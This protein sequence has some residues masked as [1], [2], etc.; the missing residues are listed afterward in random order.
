MREATE[1]L[2]Y[3][4]RGGPVHPLNL[5]A[6]LSVARRPPLRV[7][8]KRYP[9][10]A[11]TTTWRAYLD[12]RSLTDLEEAA[13]SALLLTEEIRR[14]AD[15]PEARVYLAEALEAAL[16]EFATEAT[17]AAAEATRRGGR[18]SAETRAGEAMRPRM[19]RK[20]RDMLDGGA[21]DYYEALNALV[22]TFGVNR[23][24]AARCLREAGLGRAAW[25]T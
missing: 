22:E 11:E 18:K 3:L 14:A 2:E 23:E 5:E 7:L 12:R 17:E 4:K 6:A 1:A 13:L 8:A 20:A 24:Y 16:S 9:G 10:D 21:N 25:R 19:V 15:D